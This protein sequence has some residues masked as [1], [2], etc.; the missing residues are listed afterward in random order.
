MRGE[1]EDAGKK[2]AEA[3]DLGRVEKKSR[4]GSGREEV[5]EM[6]EAER[7]GPGRGGTK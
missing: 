4:F 3:E 2:K 6:A 5:V 7:Y 1:K